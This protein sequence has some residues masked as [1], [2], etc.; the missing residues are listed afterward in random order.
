M[1]FS[2]IA[3]IALLQSN[4]FSTLSTDNEN[5]SDGKEN[6]RETNKKSHPAIND[7]VYEEIMNCLRSKLMLKCRH[8]MSSDEK[9]KLYW[10]LKK[11]IYEF[12]HINNPVYGCE[13]DLVV[14]T[15][16]ENPKIVP[17]IGEIDKIVSFSYH[18]YK[19]AYE[20]VPKIQPK[21]NRFYTGISI[22]RIQKNLNSNEN[23]FKINPIFSNKPSLSP[24][25][26]ET[27]QGCI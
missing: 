3:V 7:E 14:T 26:S 4:I 17:Q 15:N 20:G 22:K 21:T 10:V 18:T 5:V 6:E 16:E 2:S 9:K 1:L 24:V 8:I 13:K 19:G 25:I 12:V 23:H 11:G 27:V